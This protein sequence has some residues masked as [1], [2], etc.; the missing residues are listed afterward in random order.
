MIAA[1][2]G[3]ERVTFCNTGSEAVMAAMRLARAVTGNERIV[4][5][6]NDYHGQFDE[7]LVKGRNKAGNPVALP[8]APGIP[9]GSLSNM[10][11]LKYGESES[12]DWIRANAGDLAAVIVEPIQSRHPEIQ[13]V[14]FVREIRSL[15]T[16]H[17]FA[18]VFDEVVTGFRVHPG[19]MQAIWNIKADMAT[20]GKVVGGGMPVGVLAGDA[21]FMDA[22]DGGMWSY[23]DESAPM[24]AP[25][26]FA[27]TFVRH[28]LVLA[29]CRAV[30]HHIRGEGAELY[31]RVAERS[32]RLVAEIAS[33]LEARGIRNAVHGF[34]SWFTP[35][36][37]DADPLG[38]LMFPELRRRGINIHEGYPCFLTTAHSE[39]DFKA[40][41]KA[42][43]DSADA[44]Q[45]AGI[46]LG[47]GSVA[48]SKAISVPAAAPVR[49]ATAPLTEAQKEIWLSAQAG[50]EASCAFNESFTLTL[51]GELDAA[52]LRG[53]L[54]DVIARHDAF[55]IR[56]ARDGSHFTFI[57]GFRLDLPFVDLLSEKD[58]DA[59]LAAILDDEARTPLDLVNGPLVRAALVRMGDK[60][61]KLV[62]TAHHIICDGWS[63]NILIEE[64][65]ALYRARQNG[66][67]V[68]LD[69]ALSF[70]AYA[71]GLAPGAN[72]D[73]ATEAYWLKEFAIV[74]D[75]PDYPV[76]RP[77][78]EYKTYAGGTRT[79]HV[80]ADTHKR[81]K[82]AGGKAGATLF[83]TLLGAM[84]V[85]LSRLSGAEDIVIAIPSAGQSLLADAGVLAGH[86]VNLL[87]VR[88]SVHNGERF[89]THLKAT[90][91]T[92]LKAFEHQA[93][94]YGTL[95]RKLGI[96]RDPR[97]LPLTEFQFNL[98]RTGSGADFGT[99]N[100]SVVPNAKAFS[101]FDMFFNVTESASGL[102]IDVDYNGEV[103][104]SSTV[105]RW[106][107][108]FKTLLD[109]IA[110]DMGTAIGTLPL[111]GAEEFGW[112]HGVLNDT[113]AD[114]GALLPVHALFAEQ[115]ASNP[116][117]VAAIH[118][119]RS[120]TYGELDARANRLARHL[121]TAVSGSGKRIALLA[122]R[123]FDMLVS[124]L[125]IMK[126]GHT[127]VPLDC[128]HP[129]PRLRQT[130]EAAQ[131]AAIVCDNERMEALAAAGSAVIRLDRDAKAIAARAATALT[132]VD[133]DT[134]SAPPAYIIF[135]SGS[136]GTP[137]GVEISHAALSNFM[138][139]MTREPG[140]GADDT[141]IAVTTI[142]FDIAALE[143]YLPLIAGGKV[144]IA[145]RAQV[146]DGFALVDLVRAHRPTILQA[147]P[148]LWRMLVEAGLEAKPELK[149]LTGGEPLP[150]DLA[151]R[152]AALGGEVWNMYGPTETTIWSSVARIS[153]EGGPI[154]I[155]RPIANT[156]LHIVDSAD[157]L[158]PVGVTGELLIGGSGLAN[159]YFGRTDLTEKAFVSLDTGTG[160]TERL[161]RTGDVGKRLAD[162]S[163][164][165]LGRRDNQVKLRGFRI[166]LGDIE[167]VIGK[168]EGV[169]QCATVV[170]RN[171][172][173][174]AQL[175]AY[176][177]P[178]N[179]ARP[180]I[181]RDLS[182]EAN[183]SLPAYMVPSHWVFVDEL[184]QT[185]NGK[186]DRKAL[187]ERG[188]PQ[189]GPALN[190]AVRAP[191]TPLEER[192]VQIWKDVL[193]RDAIGVDENI[194]A[195]GADSLS[196]FRIASRML[197]AGLDLEAKDVMRNQS[198]S[199]LA[200]FAEQRRKAGGLNG[201]PKL[202]SLRDFRGGARRNIASA[203]Q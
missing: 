53:A 44:L 161:Y 60:V 38:S 17:G 30:L 20:Y 191:S 117:A 32:E 41:A 7:V 149:I 56:F 131:V 12:I 49:P 3:L 22:L 198:V 159:G 135:T 67:A 72:A 52:A 61:H 26:F 40:I 75:M 169:R 31:S 46:L 65:A 50:D 174:E 48:I 121:Q 95:V 126:A 73:P 202:P 180:P 167:A 114:F 90:Q 70:A 6:A 109:A 62:C 193:E 187:V 111:L 28:P 129:E 96:K 29:A 153:D 156:A 86:C 59:A 108:C 186:L 144:V 168:V 145:D 152:L 128:A 57:D 171:R 106:I 64:L 21:R 100:S 33:D 51:E 2:V 146:Q 55:H 24:T 176:I 136:T 69:P 9:A 63:I 71:T 107:G 150:A 148:T 101:N 177:V 179:P 143:L 35:H 74:P 188:V 104:D 92:V 195:I 98:E 112:L 181:D 172:S 58:S 124:L 201:S 68:R 34:K 178:R 80:D 82:K 76:D 130:L 127:Y 147:T 18:L 133:F 85:M 151:A 137:K 138:H 194:F 182:L 197:D 157:R 105:D 175:V 84:Q 8:I 23:G 162:G 94:T 183:A 11:V 39:E 99:L 77:H 203:V 37:S 97:R 166:E 154:T 173:G 54:D 200:A 102:R 164:L 15:A 13:P 116:D 163:L 14:E 10:I 165:L 25:T 88:Q 185:G 142:S 110:G 141:I 118:G 42:F 1:M 115:A 36:F 184:P 155:G 123:S 16:A 78:P 81:L 132:D 158:A 120:M 5:F 83:S 139:S 192:L 189:P 4:V 27:G 122:D 47:E 140:F 93:Y 134:A 125:A 87:P 66:Q 45:A 43:R 89:E 196:V 190:A 19:G 170:A 119:S 103:Y 113:K 79:G 199:A 91:E 160:H